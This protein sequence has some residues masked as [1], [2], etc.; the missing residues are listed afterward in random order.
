M[1]INVEFRKATLNDNAEEIAELL[2]RTDSYIYPYW[3]E[4]LENCKSELSELIKEDKFFFNINNLYIMKD[5]VNNKIIGVICVVD[6][7][8]DLSYDYSKLESVNERYNYTIKN[9]VKGLIDEVMS[10][11][12]VYISNVCVHPDYRGMHIGSIMMKKIIEIYKKK[13]FDEIV[14]D[15]LADNPAAINLYQKMGFRQI[16]DIFDGFNGPQLEKP[17]VFSMK[18]KLK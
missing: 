2:Y 10:S 9:Y 4:S 14:L 15:V 3:F 13:F 6:K 17:D 11:D 18:L 12:F 16:T 1:E 7:H 5:T 8:V